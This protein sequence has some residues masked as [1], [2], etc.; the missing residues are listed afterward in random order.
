MTITTSHTTA[1][2]TWLDR[3]D[4]GRMSKAQCQQF[5]RAV[6]AIS[7]GDIPGGHYTALRQ[8]EA[9]EL[10][11][12]LGKRPVLLEQAHTEQGLRW[13]EKGGARR[14]GLPSDVLDRFSHF[15]FDGDAW[16]WSRYPGRTFYAPVWTI[17]T[18]DGATYRY[19]AVAWQ[20]GRVEAGMDYSI[21]GLRIHIG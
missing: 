2:R 17:H 4:S 5:A 16:S 3:I 11:T 10:R 21:T 18:R 14:L 12:K 19:A 8:D 6:V 20:T 1:Y 7:R 15:S 13:L 9:A